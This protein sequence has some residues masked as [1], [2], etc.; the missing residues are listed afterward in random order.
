MKQVPKKSVNA[1]ANG[2][3]FCDPGNCGFNDFRPVNSAQQNGSTVVA[4]HHRRGTTDWLHVNEGPREKYADS[5][6]T[7][8][9]CGLSSDLPAWQNTLKWA[10]YTL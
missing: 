8:Y 9:V 1:L 7:R 3:E 4:R 2:I 10:W 5:H 6:R